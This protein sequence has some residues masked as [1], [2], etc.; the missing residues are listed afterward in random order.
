MVDTE[1]LS[2]TCLHVQS[3]GWCSKDDFRNEMISESQSFF[4]YKTERKHN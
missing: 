2:V 1:L 3:Y 4:Y